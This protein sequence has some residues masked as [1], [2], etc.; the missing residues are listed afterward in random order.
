[1]L[2]TFQA[3][4]EQR[5]APWDNPRAQHATVDAPWCGCDDRS[6]VHSRDLARVFVFVI[7]QGAAAWG[8]EADFDELDDLLQA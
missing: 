7:P 5:L 4:S 3:W 8:D 2:R 1:M 6:C